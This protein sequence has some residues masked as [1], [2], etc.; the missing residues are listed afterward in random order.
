M[1]LF[2]VE[3]ADKSTQDACDEGSRNSAQTEPTLKAAALHARSLSRHVLMSSFDHEMRTSSPHELV[4]FSTY[5]T[6]QGWPSSFAR[7]RSSLALSGFDK[8]WVQKLDM[9]TIKK[10]RNL[11]ISVHTQMKMFPSAPHE[12]TYHHHTIK[13]RTVLI[14]KFMVR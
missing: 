4:V 6:Q 3:N 12:T 10:M 11:Q 7:Q 5:S 14:D 9:R 1:I 13:L 8:S 2:I